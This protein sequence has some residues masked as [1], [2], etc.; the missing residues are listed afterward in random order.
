MRTV[1]PELKLA[2]RLFISNVWLLDDGAS[3]I[4]IDTGHPL[5]RWTLRRALWKAGVRERGDLKAVLLTHRHS[6]HAGNAA[7]LRRTFD[8]PI[9]CHP[10]DAEILSGR[11]PPPR[12][13]RGVARIHEEL[14]CRIEDRFPARSPVDELM[15]PGAWKWGL[16]VLEVPGHTEG[17]VMLHHEPTGTLFSGDAILTGPPPLRALEVLYLAVPG[18]S[19]DVGTCHERV[20]ACVRELPPIRTLCAGHGP[21]VTRDAHP[22]LLRLISG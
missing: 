15:Q 2:H 20:R 16:R 1:T 22:K 6:D 21:A 8:C 9:V 13:A 18:F 11:T 7:W 14:L 3:R 12:L 4:L 5:E 19:L 17:S 10:R